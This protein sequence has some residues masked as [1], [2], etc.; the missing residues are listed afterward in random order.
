MADFYLIWSPDLYQFIL[1]TREIILKNI[2]NIINIDCN[3]EMDE[4]IQYNED[5]IEI[6][7][8]ETTWYVIGKNY[9][10]FKLN[11]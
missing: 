5:F 1:I 9:E 7:K 11:Y 6:P 4:S 2:N 10:L 3:K 8:N